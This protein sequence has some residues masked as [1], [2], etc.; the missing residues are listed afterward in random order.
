MENIIPSAEEFLLKTTNSSWIKSNP[1]FVER[2]SLEM[3]EFAILHVEQALKAAANNAYIYTND[4]G[5]PNPD[6]WENKINIS[7]ILTAY[8]SENIK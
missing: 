2:I 1:E 6:N 4:Y 3:I 7:S 8:P 5:S